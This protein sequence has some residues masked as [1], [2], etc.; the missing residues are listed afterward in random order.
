MIRDGEGR[1]P[2][3]YIRVPRLVLVVATAAVGIVFLGSTVSAAWYPKVTPHDGWVVVLEEEGQL[4]QGTQVRLGVTAN[5]EEGTV[6]YTVSACGEGD[7]ELLLLIGGGARLKD[8]FANLLGQPVDHIDSR[9]ESD[10][11]G[12][13]FLSDVQ[14]VEIEIV[15]MRPCRA[16][17]WAGVVGASLTGEPRRQ[18]FNRNH[19]VPRVREVYSFPL[20]G[21]FPGLDA[22]L[23]GVFHLGH[24]SGEFFRPIPLNI[25]LYA[26]SVPLDRTIESSRPLLDDSA[27]LSWSQHTPFQSEAVLRRDSFAAPAAGLSAITGVLLGVAIGWLLPKKTEGEKRLVSDLPRHTPVVPPPFDERRVAGGWWAFAAAAWMLSKLLSR[28]RRN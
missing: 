15:D 8:P 26:G 10:G 16:D 5:A 19:W 20:I 17:G 28:V 27:S 6:N 7:A 13:V 1:S 11:S 4:A 18:F 9:V 12:G 22:A 24:T 3:S 25:D 2:P 21:Q 14:Q 23:G